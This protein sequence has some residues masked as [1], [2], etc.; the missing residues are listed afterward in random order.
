MVKQVPS[1]KL[2]NVTEGLTTSCF[3]VTIKPSKKLKKPKAVVLSSA[4]QHSSPLK[5]VIHRNY[6]RTDSN[7]SK[8]Y[9]Y[10]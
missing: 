8:A 1:L 10:S 7:S 5:L 6:N 2:K 4:S 3:L 9:T